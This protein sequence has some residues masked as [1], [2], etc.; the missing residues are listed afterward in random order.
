[1]L[2]EGEPPL[3]VGVGALVLAGERFLRLRSHRAG[4]VEMEIRLAGRGICLP[5]LVDSGNQLRDP[6]KGQPVVV[7]E[8]AALGDFLPVDVREW[9][10]AGNGGD[11]EPGDS[12]WSGRLR[13]IPF[14]SLGQQRGVMLGFKPDAVLLEGREVG[15]L[16]VATARQKL[17]AT[18]IYRALVPSVLLDGPRRGAA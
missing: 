18:G 3:V 13:I 14:Q 7:V 5:A 16:V 9:L 10:Q 4:F 15:Q 6:L 17:S 8:M 1:L 2:Q 11:W 12:P